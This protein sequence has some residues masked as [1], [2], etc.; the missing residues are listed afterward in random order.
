MIWGV[1]SRGG[2]AL[3]LM[4]V[5]LYA[6]RAV[7][8]LFVECT[9]GGRCCRAVRQLCNNRV[10][11]LFPGFTSKRYFVWF[12]LRVVIGVLLWYTIY[13]EID[14]VK[15]SVEI[16]V[17]PWQLYTILCRVAVWPRQWSM[18]E[19]GVYQFSLQSVINRWGSF[20][21]CTEY[22]GCMLILR[23]LLLVRGDTG[24]V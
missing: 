18:M 23:C 14:V 12:F 11:G 8:L 19:F 16:A 15:S 2:S 10:V 22:E 20:I 21:S 5:I 24:F 9:T 4:W 3:G 1:H 13:T 7:T 6:R 17:L